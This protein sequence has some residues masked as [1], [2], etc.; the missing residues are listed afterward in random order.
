MQRLHLLLAPISV[1]FLLYTEEIPRPT[2][3][4]SHTQ[5]A[6]DIRAVGSTLSSSSSKIPKSFQDAGEDSLFIYLLPR[7]FEG[8]FYEQRLAEFGG[9][10]GTGCVL[11]SFFGVCIFPYQTETKFPPL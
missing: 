8:N 6:R 5:L 11:I 9:C 1:L 7:G 3:L 10:L 4:P 2:P